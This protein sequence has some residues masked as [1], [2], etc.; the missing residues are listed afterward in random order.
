[1]YIWSQGDVVGYRG[2][3][4]DRVK[5]YRMDSDFLIWL[6]LLLLR[7]GCLTIAVGCELSCEFFLWL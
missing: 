7:C 2:E 1:M 6:S 5:M 4:S 3:G